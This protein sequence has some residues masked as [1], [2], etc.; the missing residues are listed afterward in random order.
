MDILE[1]GVFVWTIYLYDAKRQT[2]NQTSYDN[3]AG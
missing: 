3:A 1:V 2:L